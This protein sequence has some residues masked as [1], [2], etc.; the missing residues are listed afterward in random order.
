[1]RDWQQIVWLASYPKSGNTWARCVFD[2][3]MLDGELDIN[4]M[5]ASV[6]DNKG[7]WVR[8]P[9]QENPAAAP[10]EIGAMARHCGLLQLVSAYRQ[11]PDPPMPLVVKT[12]SANVVVHGMATLPPQLSG[13]IIHI[14]RDPRDMVPSVAAHMGVSTTR[15]AEAMTGGAIGLGSKDGSVGSFMLDWPRH[16]DSYLNDAGQCGAPVLTVR[17][18]DL[19]A[20]PETHFRAMLEH[21]DIAVNG[22][23][24]RRAIE[25]SSLDRVRAQEQAAGFIEQSHKATGTFFGGER[26]KMRPSDKSIITRHCWRQMQRLGYIERRATG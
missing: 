12:H 7:P 13:K 21:A 2:A 19:K 20:D 11:L 17:Y 18:E 22:D 16:T 23:R 8:L 26:P 10:Q 15:A 4:R 9:N 6:P 24:L 1:M 5:A 3:Y 25:A 14:V